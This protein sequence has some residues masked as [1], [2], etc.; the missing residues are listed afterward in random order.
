MN[1]NGKKAFINIQ[2]EFERYRRLMNYATDLFTTHSVEDCS[3]IYA[4]PSVKSV[5]GYRPDELIGKKLA[6]LCHPNDIEKITVLF[7]KIECQ[8]AEMRT[9]YRIRR[10]EGDYIWFETACIKDGKEDAKELLCISKD[11]TSYKITEQELE[12]SKEKY[13][14]LIEN[15]QDTVGIVTKDGYWI[16]IN[17]AGRKLF[18]VTRKEEIIG[19][20]IMEFIVPKERERLKNELS[21]TA[22][23]KSIDITVLRTDNKMKAVDMK[24]LPSLYRERQTFQ[25]V[26][27]DVTEQKKAEEIIYQKEKLSV[28]GQLAAGIA[29]EIRNPLTA[30]KGFTQLLKTEESNEYLDI[31]MEEMERIE[32]IVSDLL[33]LGKPQAANIEMVNIKRILQRTISLFHAEAMLHNIE[34]VQELDLSDP[35]I[36]GEADKLKQVLINLIKNAMESM[37][38]GGEII[39]RAKQLPSEEILIQVM[40]NGVGIPPERIEKLGEPFFSN[41]EKG[42]GLGLMICNRIIKNHK[43]K[44]EIDSEVNKGTTISI[45]LHK[46]IAS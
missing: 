3:I 26:L 19:K 23:S 35:Y 41:K 13:E 18:G 11:I 22:L 9:E 4:S 28:I 29:H 7:S 34:I 36:E 10:K 44:M 12:E 37:P 5:L 31:M 38:K 2:E 40:D 6:D 33:V 27:R 15:F 30:V 16:Y 46:K 1:N 20:N 14:L 45:T 25:I 43:G 17:D 42:T 32:Q 8:Q 39:I 21:K 24:F